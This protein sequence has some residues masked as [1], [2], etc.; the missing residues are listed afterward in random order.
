MTYSHMLKRK[1]AWINDI[2]TEIHE[3]TGKQVLASIQIEKTYLE[4]N[5]SDDE[6]IDIMKFGM[7]SPVSGI[8][9]FHYDYILNTDKNKFRTLSLKPDKN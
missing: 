3:R 5:I 2:T 6:F 9:L 7:M 8:I 4:E 1:P